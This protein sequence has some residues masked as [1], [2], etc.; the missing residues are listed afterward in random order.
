MET[1]LLRTDVMIFV[2]SKKVSYV[3]TSLLFVFHLVE[4]DF[5]ILLKKNV[6]IETL[7]MM[8]DVLTNVLLKLDGNVITVL[9]LLSARLFVEISMFEETKLAMLEILQF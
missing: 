3:K 2:R 5:I 8:M 1:L 4:T 6:M 9:F 7:S